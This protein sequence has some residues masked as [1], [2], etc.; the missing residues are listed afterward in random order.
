VEFEGVVESRSGTSWVISGTPVIIDSNT[1][2]EDDPQVGDTVKVE[3]V[4]QSNGQLLATKIE[5][6]D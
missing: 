3:A 4:T 2:I 6:E 5:K 1:E